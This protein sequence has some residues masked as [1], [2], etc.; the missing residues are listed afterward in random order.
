MRKYLPVLRDIA[1]SIVLRS[2]LFLSTTF[3]SLAY[4]RVLKPRSFLI[5]IP[6]ST[7]FKMITGIAHVNLLVPKGTLDL[8][9]SFYGNTLGFTRVPV[10]VLQRGTLAW[11]VSSSDR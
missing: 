4:I 7:K 8:A 6:Y 3:A 11:Y 1:P 2:G 10:P 9:E 5:D